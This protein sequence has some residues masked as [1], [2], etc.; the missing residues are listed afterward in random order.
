[1]M[2]DAARAAVVVAVVLTMSLRETHVAGANC[3]AQR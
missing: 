2:K 3:W 1:M